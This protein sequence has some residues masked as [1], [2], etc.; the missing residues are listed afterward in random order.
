[1]ILEAVSFCH[2]NKIM[3]RDI[4]PS[5]KYLVL[6][7][8]NIHY[9]I[10]IENHLFVTDFLVSGRGIVKLADFGLARVFD[11]AAPP[12]AMSHQIATRWCVCCIFCQH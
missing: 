12:L 11:P 10:S 4:K 7:A 6:C 9:G 3:H 8:N 5:S 1:M 2:L